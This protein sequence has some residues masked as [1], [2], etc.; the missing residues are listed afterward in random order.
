M[1]KK[2]EE[3]LNPQVVRAKLVT[4]GLF[5]V[6]YETL[7]TAIVDRV[8][9]FYTS[10]FNEKGFIVDPAYSEKVLSL[11]PKGKR[12]ALRSSLVWLEKND[13]LTKADVEQFVAVKNVRNKIAHELTTFIGGGAELPIDDFFSVAIG[14]LRKIE[15]WWTVNVE[16]AVDPE[17]GD[18]EIDEEEIVPG[19]LLMVQI[20]LDV[21]LGDDEEAAKHLK[22][23][24]AALAA[25]R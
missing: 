19:S 16:M 10:G 22:A 8:V 9:S 12:D 25:R 14:L 7:E 24:Q 17:W 4:S 1:T 6:A 13:A 11:D 23:F 18:K 2:W 5:I 21:A 15:V 3:F 20:L